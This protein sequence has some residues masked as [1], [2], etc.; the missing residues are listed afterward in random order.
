MLANLATQD[1]SHKS[2]VKVTYKNCVYYPTVTC[3][4]CR[5]H[6]INQKRDSSSFDHRFWSF[7]NT[8]SHIVFSTKNQFFLI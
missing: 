5:Y 4:S 7:D 3:I 1:K 6:T 2:Q 8:D